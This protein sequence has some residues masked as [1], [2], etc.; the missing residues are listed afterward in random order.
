MYK[1]CSELAVFMNNLL[2]YCKLVDATTRASNKDLS[3]PKYL[4]YI[5]TYG[6]DG[7]DAVGLD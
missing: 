3:V 5:L 4:V 6:D 7:G 2:S 1:A